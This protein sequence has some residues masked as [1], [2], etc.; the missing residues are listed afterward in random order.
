MHRLLLLFLA[1]FS[2][3]CISARPEVIETPAPLDGPL[4]L[5]SIDGF[6]WDYID[7]HEPQTIDSLARSGVRSEGLIAPFPSKTFP[8]HFTQVTGLYPANH[9]VVSN[10]MYDPSMDATF[11]LSDELAQE[12]PEW[13]SGEP[14]WV[15]ATKNNLVSACMFW[16]GSST[17]H[18][19]ILPNHYRVFDQS[20]TSAQRVDQL[21]EW[22]S[23]PQE[24][25]PDFATLYFDIV[26][27]AGHR[28]GPESPEVRS[29]VQEVDAAIRKLVNGLRSRGINRS[30]LILVSDHGMAEI[31]TSRVIFLDDF[32]DLSAVRMVDWSPIA[33]LRPPEDLVDSI[34]TALHGKHPRLS[35]YRGGKDSNFPER[36]H[37]ENNDRI[38]PIVA[39]ADEGWTITT[40]ASYRPNRHRGATHGYDS[41]LKSMQGLF[42][43]NG[44]AFHSGVVIDATESIHL[45]NLMARIL[46]ITPAQND[47][48]SLLIDRALLDPR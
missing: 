4:I 7:L 38:Q 2:L 19:G 29:A 39:V 34:Y 37:F 44:P 45:Y 28:N 43:G 31:D 26:D 3:S 20:L 41:Q 47:G 24:R 8:S 23:L 27:S 16:P 10:T 6:R 42:V 33:A 46:S 1:C 18:S 36:Y 11:R 12:N 25:R 15:T 35:V 14:I 30:N 17:A 22:M 5:V 48:G 40:R 13:W 9:G 32:I 21:L